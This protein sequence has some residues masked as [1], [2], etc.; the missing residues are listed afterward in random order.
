MADEQ[1]PGPGHNRGVA[2]DRLRSF[3]QRVER[4]DAEIAN[5]RGDRKDVLA[6][7]K[8]DGLDTKIIARILRERKK[9]RDALAEEEALY[10]LYTSVL[11]GVFG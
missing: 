5:L 11:G 7:A 10:D 9:D 2:G 6:E 4:L 8:G 3:I 1:Q